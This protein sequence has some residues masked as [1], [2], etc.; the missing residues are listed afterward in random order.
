MIRIVLPC[1]LLLLTHVAFADELAW[2]RV[3]LDDTFRSE[4]VAAGDVNRDGKMDVF[5]GDVWYQAPDWTMHEFRPL[6]K[7]DFN[8]GYSNSFCNFA[9]DVNGDGWVDVIV[10]GFPGAPFH[11]YENPQ[12][13]EGHWKEHVIWHSVCN[14]SP[15][16][17]DIDGDGK[18]ELLL[19]SQPESQMGIIPLPAKEKATQKWDFR[20]ISEPG[21]PEQN[22]THRFYHGVGVGDV[23]KDGRNDVVIPHGWWEQPSTLTDATWKFHAWTLAREGEQNPLPAANIYVDD[24]DLDGDQDVIMSCAHAYGVWWFERMG[25]QPDAEVRYH[26]IDESFSQSHA[27]KYVDLNGD[28]SRDLVT[29]KRFWAHQGGDPGEREPVVMCWYEIKKQAGSPPQFVKHEIKEGLDTGIGTQF[30]VADM[31]GDKRPDIVLSN[32]KGVNL[33]IQKAK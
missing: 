17:V 16:F 29:G 8:T 32:K 14:E 21:V 9:H 24:L 22:G 11:W 26:V 20:A 15:D 30:E 4:G 3:K 10:V 27:L 7:Y 12:G 6:G 5:A 33:L 25:N 18:P 28:G 2:E 1:A 31:N 13:K 19:G 23:N